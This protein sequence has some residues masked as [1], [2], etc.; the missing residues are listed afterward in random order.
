VGLSSIISPF[1]AALVDEGF[2]VFGLFGFGEGHKGNLGGIF[3][4]VSSRSIPCTPR[5]S[6]AQSMG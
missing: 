2:A 3:Y 1:L 6:F 4:T 5:R